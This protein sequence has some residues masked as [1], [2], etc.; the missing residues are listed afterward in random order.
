MK[1]PWLAG[2][3]RTKLEARASSKSAL[4]RL[5]LNVI[6]NA[7]LLIEKAQQQRS[8]DIIKDLGPELGVAF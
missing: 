2:N 8:P 4:R 5:P 1:L 6:E 3:G 7:Q